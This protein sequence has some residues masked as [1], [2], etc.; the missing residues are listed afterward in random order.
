MAV[1]ELPVTSDPQAYTFQITLDGTPYNVRFHYNRRRE[2]WHMSIATQD[3]IDLVNGVPIFVNWPIL[4]RFKDTRLPPG[5][6]MAIDT[7][8]ETIDPGQD[9]FGTRVKMTY[10]EVN[11]F[12]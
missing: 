8:G 6:F 9:D 1:Q 5:T 3:N 10:I 2:T 11:T 7:T 12:V 4:D